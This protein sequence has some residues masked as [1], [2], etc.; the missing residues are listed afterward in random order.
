[1]RSSANSAIS[2][3][4]KREA[5]LAVRSAIATLRDKYWT[6]ESWLELRL[7]KYISMRVFK[8][9]AKIF[10][11][12][13]NA[14]GEWERQMLLPVPDSSRRSKRYGIRRDLPVP[15]PF[16]SPEATKVAM[17]TLLSVG[18]R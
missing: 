8:F 4:V 7:K 9:G 3:L 14:D 10:S 1:M 15:S 2:S 13:M 11:H 5:Y 17:D 12:Q 16:R 6:A 18:G